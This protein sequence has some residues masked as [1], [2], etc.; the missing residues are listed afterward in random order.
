MAGILV[1][2]HQ[3]LASALEQSARHVFS[4][5]PRCAEYRLRALDV[6]PD[7]DPAL[8]EQRA[9]A[10]LAE[11]DD[12]R[13][14]LVLTDCLGATPANVAARLAQPGAV[15]V[16]AGANLPMLLRALCYCDSALDALAEKALAGGTRGI[17]SI[18][19]TPPPDGQSS[20]KDNDLARLQ[21]QQ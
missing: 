1:I 21:D 13:G 10:L 12:G 8:L 5:D 19:P 6:E 14:V 20:V 15:E 16:V 7:A 17:A 9:R 2:A 4:R 18:G 3:P 11:A